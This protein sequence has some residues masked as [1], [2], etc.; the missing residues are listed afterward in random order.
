MGDTA[1]GDLVDSRSVFEAPGA[2]VSER[3]VESA[4]RVG[5]GIEHVDEK[6]ST[7]IEGAANR[8]ERCPLRSAVWQVKQSVEGDDGDAKGAP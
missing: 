7:R 2:F 5:S 4:Q 6:L 3:V 1:G 8:G